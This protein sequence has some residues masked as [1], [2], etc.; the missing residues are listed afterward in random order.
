MEWSTPRRFL[1]VS[2]S[3]DDQWNQVLQEALTVLGPVQVAS[4]GELNACLQERIYDAV[5]VDAGAVSSPLEELI[6][7]IQALDSGVKIVI[8]TASPHWKIAKAVIRA[9]A[10][11]YLE[12][13]LNR[14]EII[15]SF[16]AI[17]E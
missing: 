5:I 11:D 7:Q 8:V 6:F 1:L 13:S 12:K 3:A 9:G 15:S 14:E 17:L 2:R 10:A 4:E 16:R